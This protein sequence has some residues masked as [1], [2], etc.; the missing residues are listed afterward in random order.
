MALAKEQ[1]QL[2]I[3]CISRIAPQPRWVNAFQKTASYEIAYQNPATAPNRH[4]GPTSH[5]THVSR[6]D[7][8]WGMQGAGGDANT[9][10]H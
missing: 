7:S 1:T 4:N 10:S 2:G 9:S 5:I 3:Y 6:S 8:T